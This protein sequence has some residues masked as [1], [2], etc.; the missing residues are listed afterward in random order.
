MTRGKLMA[1]NVVVLVVAAALAR[2]MPHLPANFSP[3]G[4]MGLFAGGML[5]WPLAL[6]V[7]LGGLLLSD[8]VVGVYSPALMLFVY[9]GM[10]ANV[11]LGKTFLKFRP[12][13]VEVAG[14]SVA[15]AVLFFVV[16]NFGY[17]VVSGLYPPTFAGLAA[18]YIAAV[19]FFGN[20]LLGQ[21]V[22]GGLL[23]GLNAC[24]ERFVATTAREIP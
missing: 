11:V 22:F 9:A 12:R 6:A 18:C 20:T 21:L 23:F 16:S 2:L 8:L 24:A 7:S 19:P 5:P 15:G 10:A 14:A 4:A 3:V 17:W 13:A 1:A